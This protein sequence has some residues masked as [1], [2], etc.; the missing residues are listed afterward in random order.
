MLRR[1]KRQLVTRKLGIFADNNCNFKQFQ[2]SQS[3]E[4]IAFVIGKTLLMTSYEISRQK[5]AQNA[6]VREEFLAYPIRFLGNN[7]QAVLLKSSSEHFYPAGD[8][9]C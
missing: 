4:T 7:T 9:M 6:F 5:N 1:Y 8:T 2:H 3:A